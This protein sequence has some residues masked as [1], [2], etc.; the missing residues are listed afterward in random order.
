VT[1]RDIASFELLVDSPA[2]VLVLAR[3]PWWTLKRALV[4]LG[5]LVCVLAFTVLWLTQLRRQVEERTAELET[6]IRERQRVEHQRAIEEERARIARDLH[7]ELGSGITEIGMLAARAQSASAAGGKPARHVEQMGERAREMVTAMDEIVWA[8]N[9]R[10]DSLASLVSY[11]GLHADRF[12]GLANIAW[13]LEGPATLPEV[14][15]DSR[16][17][18]QL[19]LAFKEALTNVVRHSGASEVRLGVRFEKGCLQLSVSDN[20]GGLPAPAR[21]AGMDGVANMRARVEKLGGRFEMT[22]A[23]GR[24]TVVR[25]TV[26][27]G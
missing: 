9:P 20:G 12:L 14:A 26:P 19:F 6:Q 4:I 25:F 15:V 24:G 11:L 10:H 2:D 21:D 23:A 16:H 8:M 1:G 7:D 17:R 18:H 3:P 5:A 22:S 13:R 27:I